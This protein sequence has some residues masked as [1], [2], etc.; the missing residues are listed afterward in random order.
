MWTSDDKV[1]V[2]ESEIIGKCVVKK[3]WT[4]K[5]PRAEDLSNKAR[6]NSLQGPSHYLLAIISKRRTMLEE[7]LKRSMFVVGNNN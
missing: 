3:V 7:K 2:D 5:L 1:L 4:E 6:P